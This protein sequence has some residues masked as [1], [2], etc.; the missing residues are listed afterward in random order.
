MKVLNIHT[1][2]INQ[3]Q[4]N[5]MALVKTLSSSDDKVWPTDKWPR[6]KL[7]NGLNIG[8]K[9]GHG[10]IK[11]FIQNIVPDHSIQFQFVSPKGFKGI[12]TF[13]I[14]EINP[15]QTQVKHI[16]DMNTQGLDSLKWHLVIRWLHDALI[17]DAFDK[18]ENHF[19]TTPKRSSWNI[20]VRFLRAVLK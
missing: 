14:I 4:A 16:I 1:R 11:Y 3:S 5:V 6:M 17:E 13:E 15:Q 9:G 2:V 19:S 10:P 20:W 12:H 18:I 8:S 7:D